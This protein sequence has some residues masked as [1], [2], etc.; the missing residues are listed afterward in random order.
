MPIWHIEELSTLV[1]ANT[2]ARNMS[3]QITAEDHA[4]VRT[5]LLLPQA[6]TAF[7]RDKRI[8]SESAGLRTQAPMQ[9]LSSGR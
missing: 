4:L 2:K 5:Y 8:L 9:K 7:E 3:T 6:L 1:K